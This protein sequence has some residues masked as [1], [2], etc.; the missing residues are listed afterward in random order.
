[1]AF[2]EFKNIQ[3]VLQHYPLR[4]VKQEFLPDTRLE[5][6]NWLIDNFKFLLRRELDGDS[7]AFF[8]E[9]FIFPFLQFAWQRHDRLKLWLHKTIRYDDR[10][11]GEPDYFLA[12]W[13]EE[14][15]DTLV[16]P[17]LL[18]IV[19]AKRQDFDEGW[20]QCLAAMIACQK[21]NENEPIT[22]HGI[23]STGLIW[24][25]GK[26]DGNC[27]TKDILSYSIA[28]PQRVAGLLDAIFAECERQIPPRAA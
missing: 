26:L 13:P 7:E 28:E 1:M 25:F 9:A 24:E 4:F 27:F 18:A 21:L 23:V 17:P 10:L 16:L 20:G 22:I 6:P 5:L 14:V 3:Q 19:E 8:R 2:S 12:R 15:T 11:Y